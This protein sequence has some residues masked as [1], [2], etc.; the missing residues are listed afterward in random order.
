[1]SDERQPVD[2]APKD[3]TV[4]Y[5]YTDRDGRTMFEGKASWRTVTFPAFEN[6]RY[7]I[8]PA[9]TATGWMR[10]GMDKMMP[11]PTHW[12]PLKTSKQT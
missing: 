4:I 11:G 9:W 1:M 3:G 7:G 12:T 6:G 2:T 10:D 8:E 5:A